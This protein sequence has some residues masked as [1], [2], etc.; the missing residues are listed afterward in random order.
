MLRIEYSQ[1]PRDSEPETH[2]DRDD[3]SWMETGVSGREVLLLL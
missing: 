2:C 1:Y 3:R